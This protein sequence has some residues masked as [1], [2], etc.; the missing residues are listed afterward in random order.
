TA[1]RMRGEQEHEA[2]NGVLDYAEARPQ[3]FTGLA[4]RDRGHDPKTFET[5]LLRHRL[6]NAALLAKLVERCDE[7]RLL[8]SASALYLATLA[9]PPVLA[10]Y[11]LAKPQAAVDEVSGKHLN[12]ATNFYGG[13]A[14][15]GAKT[16]KQKKLEA[17]QAQKK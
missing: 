4:A 10:A 5:K 16:R 7:S 8:L 11:E 13:V 15:A 14:R 6:A 3:Y 1:Q 17:E 12:P 2:L 9:K